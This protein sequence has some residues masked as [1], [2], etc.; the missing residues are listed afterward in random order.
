MNLLR[1]HPEHLAVCTIART[2][3]GQLLKLH[4]QV[5]PV[6]KREVTMAVD[7]SQRYHLLTNDALI[8]ATM[9]L[10]RLTHLATNDEDFHHVPHLTLWR[11]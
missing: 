8:L 9:I 3:I 10:H 5:L 4:V 11:P 7:L 1:R 2:F 6:G